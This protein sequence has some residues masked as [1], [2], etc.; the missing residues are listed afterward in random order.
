[1]LAAILFNHELLRQTDE[2]SIM[3]SYVAEPVRVFVLNHFANE[4]STMFFEP[5]YRIVNVRHGEHDA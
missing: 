2:K 4:L 5:G 3:G 1:L